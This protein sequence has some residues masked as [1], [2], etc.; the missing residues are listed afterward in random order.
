MAVW[1]CCS[2]ALLLLMLFHITFYSDL[3]L[4]QDQSGD[5]IRSWDYNTTSGGGSGEEVGS[6]SGS[7]GESAGEGDEGKGG[8]EKEDSLLHALHWE[9]LVEEELEEKHQKNSL[10]L[11]LAVALLM[12]VVLTIWVFKMKRCRVMHETGFSIVYG[13]IIGLIMRYAGDE[14]S[15]EPMTCESNYTHPP[16][17]VFLSVENDTYAFDLRNKLFK[18]DEGTEYEGLLLFNP[19]MFFFVLLPPII[20]Y[21]GYDLQRK[22]FFRNI[23]AI[24][25]YA[26]VGT[27]ISCFTIGSMMYAYTQFGIETLPRGVDNLVQC[28]IFGALI[29]ATDPVTVLAIFHDLHVDVDLFAIVFGESV[30]NDAVAIVLYRSI[31]AYSPSNEYPSGFDFVAVL[32]SV[33]LFIGIFVGSFLIGVLMG[34]ITALFT[35]LSKIREY[36]MME[37]GLFCLMSYA[38]FL[39]AEAA[40]MTGIVAV[41]F[42]G[43]TQAHYTYFNL[44]EESKKTTRTFFELINLLAE[45][46]VFIYMGLALFTFRYHQWNWGFIVFSFLAI[47][48]G[49]ALNIIPMTFIANL[50]RKNKIPVKFQKMLLFAGLRG[51]IAFAL[52]MRNTESEVRQLFLTTTL[53]IVFVTVLVNGGLTTVGLQYLKIDIGVK[54]NPDDDDSSTVDTEEFQGTAETGIVNVRYS[55]YQ[56]TGVVR[57]WTNAD[58]KYVRPVFTRRGPPLTTVFP[59]SLRWLAKALTGPDIQTKDRQIGHGES[60]E[61]LVSGPTELAF[62]DADDGA[63][64]GNAEM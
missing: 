18:D 16:R 29:S 12:L 24:L 49:R 31:S 59:S 26:F 7:S 5:A 53:V 27:T 20:F 42:C 13:I 19:E 11:L 40:G 52:A 36:P 50:R 58:R 57:V 33:G 51:A 54:S 32:K 28:L 3:V 39:A 23:G 62:N 17:Q 61:N 44:S 63:A 64:E 14:V 25:L 38:S 4:A 47:L 2:K 60:E 43:I 35:K 37:S 46:F 41:L 9:G 1:K 55:Q 10:S 34:F 30:M 21:A 6:G 48:A 45:N 15:V 22:Y 56:A 8:E